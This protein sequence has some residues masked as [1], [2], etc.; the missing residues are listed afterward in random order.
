MNRREFGK[1]L[2]GIPLLGLLAKLVK[3]GAESQFTAEDKAWFEAGQNSTNMAGQ[4]PWSITVDGMDISEHV[5]SWNGKTIFVDLVA[6]D[7]ANDGL[8]PE[9]A[10]TWDG[11]IPLV[12]LRECDMVICFCPDAEL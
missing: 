7:D 4:P 10:V 12:E 8:T 2:A 1:A 6:G 5:D 3:M 9:T 11:W